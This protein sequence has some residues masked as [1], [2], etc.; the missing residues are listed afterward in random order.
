[1]WVSSM[2]C[3]LSTDVL[4]RAAFGPYCSH[5]ASRTG[6]PSPVL[7][8]CLRRVGGQAAGKAM[9]SSIPTEQYQ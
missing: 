8:G 7:V 2:N 6:P 9:F 5:L 1:V 4:L 3:R